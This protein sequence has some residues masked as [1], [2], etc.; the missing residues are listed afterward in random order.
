L[1]PIKDGEEYTEALGLQLSVNDPGW[2]NPFP[3]KRPDPREPDLFPPRR[4]DPRWPEPD[5][6][7]WFPPRR[8]GNRRPRPDRPVSP[9]WPE[10][11]PEIIT[12]RR[13]G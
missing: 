9:E 7:G 6:P 2:P 3:P 5:S 1:H 10:L 11:P 12:R 13:L 8:P 4:P